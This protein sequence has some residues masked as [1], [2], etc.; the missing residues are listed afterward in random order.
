ML[1]S[2]ALVQKH[3]TAERLDNVTRG[4]HALETAARASPNCMETGD[5]IGSAKAFALDGETWSA[6]PSGERIHLAP[7][8][9]V[10]APEQRFAF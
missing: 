4:F 9:L 10:K 3:A 6:K 5:A 1:I 7:Y 8:D 2:I